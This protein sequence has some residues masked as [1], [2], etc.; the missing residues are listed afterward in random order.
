MLKFSGSGGL[1]LFQQGNALY[2]YKKY[3]RFVICVFNDFIITV[4]M[5]GYKCSAVCNNIHELR[6]YKEVHLFEADYQGMEDCIHV[7]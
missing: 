7:K 2:I 5:D 4:D 3:V 1:P 6:T